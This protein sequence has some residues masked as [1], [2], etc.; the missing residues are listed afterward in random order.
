MPRRHD[1]EFCEAAVRQDL[2]VEAQADECLAALADLERREGE[3]GV[4]AG[5]IAVEREY[6][7]KEQAGKI[8][9]TMDQWLM[10][11]KSCGA[12]IRDDTTIHGI[13]FPP[14]C[15]KCGAQLICTPNNRAREGSA[16][17]VGRL[18][19]A[20]WTQ[21]RDPLIGARIADFKIL[22][23]LGAG[24]M[25]TVYRANNLKLDCVRALKVLDTTTR[26]SKDDDS[27][28]DMAQRFLSEAQLAAKLVH[29]N[30]V[31]VHSVGTVGQLHYIEMELV[32]GPTLEAFVRQR[33][34]LPLHEATSIIRQVAEGL[35]SGHAAGIVHRDVKASNVLMTRTGRP[36][37]SD[38]GLAKAV[39]VPS[40][41]TSCGQI[42][43][44]PPCMSPEQ[45]RGLPAGPESDVYSLGILYYYTLVG[46]LPYVGPSLKVIEAHKTALLPDLRQMCPDVTPACWAAVQRM[47]A[48]SPSDRY[49]S[50]HEVI[51]A[52][53]RV[54]SQSKPGGAESSVLSVSGNSPRPPHEPVPPDLEQKLAGE[55]DAIRR[56]RQSVLRAAKHDDPVLILG[57]PGSGKEAV[58]RA[59]HGRS[60]RKPERF[61]A[62]NCGAIPSDLL[63]SELFGRRDGASTGVRS[64]RDGL[65]Q[66]ASGGT[67]FL[68]EIDAL[69]P[70]HQNRV[71]YAIEHGGLIPVGSDE[72]VRV[73]ARVIA[74]S[75][76]DLYA[77]VQMGQF[78]DGLYSCLRK[79]MIRTPALRD[80]AEDV[81][82]LA[83]FLWQGIT[84]GEGQLLA[85][86]FLDE[87]QSYSWPGNVG[88]L[89]VALQTVHATFGARDLGPEHFRAALRLQGQSLVTAQTSASSREIDLHRV[90]C[91][92]HLRR[93]DDV[94]RACKVDARPVVVDG[95][96]DPETVGSVHRAM[97]QH[98]EEI[99]AICLHPLRFHSEATFTVVYELKGK[100]MYLCEL[101][102]TNVPE[103]RAYWAGELKGHI[104]KTGHEVFREFSRLVEEG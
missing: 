48:K 78:R 96:T 52:L 19:L 17:Q 69:P 100:L 13:S 45:C 71:L 20:W 66:M 72:L 9:S 79:S 11:C 8:L 1:V 39:D 55:S 53:D 6:L 91:L 57:E 50:A 42:L 5:D 90:E 98:L 18:D 12:S 94:V 62:V 101:L 44:T 37:L 7:S 82:P 35:A 29:E 41:L 64:D 46:G 10:G 3:P 67:L 47:T 95:K 97:L 68:A 54:L 43:G 21:R 86:G 93:A 58:A 36:K 30:V 102:P 56:V 63:E 75:N 51:D 80:A 33:G 73:S 77:M 16:T 4:D 74:A 92:R 59:I 26:Q 32:E 25:G 61:T 70:D 87:L 65:W 15:P 38:F 23:I 76:R 88:E 49:P 89:K 24:G 60:Q 22:D 2:M 103:A 27:V 28:S 14:R 83:Q 104:K 85:D 34:R 40:D 99:D 84:R 81:R 31:T